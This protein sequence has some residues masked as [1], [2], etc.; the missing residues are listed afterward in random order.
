MKGKEK[1]HERERQREKVK[2][3]RGVC[4]RNGVIAERIERVR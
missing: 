4:G 3:K 2:K 1:E